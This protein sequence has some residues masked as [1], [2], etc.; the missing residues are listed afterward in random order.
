MPIALGP[1]DDNSSHLVGGVT[2]GPRP[3]VVDMRDFAASGARPWLSALYAET[4]G[5]MADVGGAAVVVTE[6]P[7]MC[8]VMPGR[9]ARNVSVRVDCRRA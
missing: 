6:Q 5:G 2:F 8:A 1:Y 7:S 9:G 4:V 3:A